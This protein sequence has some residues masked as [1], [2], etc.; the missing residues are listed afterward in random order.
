MLT[1]QQQIDACETAN[2]E[3]ARK[4]NS[5]IQDCNNLRAQVEYHKQET[6]REKAK[7]GD[8]KRQLDWHARM[9]FDLVAVLKA[10]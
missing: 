3:L 10:R 7:V 4:L 1:K 5:T 9:N 2:I 6:D 8:L